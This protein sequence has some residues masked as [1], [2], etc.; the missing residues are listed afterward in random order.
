MDAKKMKAGMKKQSDG[1]RRSCC[2]LVFWVCCMALQHWCAAQ[3]PFEVEAFAKID[4]GQFDSVRY[5]SDS[6]FALYREEQNVAEWLNLKAELG[7]KLLQKKH[8]GEPLFYADEAMYY[9]ESALRDVWGPKPPPKAAWRSWAKIHLRIG[10][11]YSQ[12]RGNFEQALDYYE[13]GRRFLQDSLGDD[14]LYLANVV[15]TPLGK[16]HQRFRDYD[17]ASQCFQDAIRIC[18][19]EQNQ[20]GEAIALNGMGIM[21]LG[22]GDYPRAIR[23]FERGGALDNLSLHPKALLLINLGLARLKNKEPEKAWQLS[24]EAKWQLEHSAVPLPRN[25]SLELWAD[26]HDNLGNLYQYERKWD[27]AKKHFQMFAAYQIE[28]FGANRRETAQAWLEFCDL[29]SDMGAPDSTLHYAQLAL[30]SLFPEVA[31]DDVFSNPLPDSI[32]V[33]HTLYLIFE[34]KVEALKALVARNPSDTILLARCLETCDLLFL[35]DELLRREYDF[36]LSKLER[37]QDVH[38]HFETALAAGYRLWQLKSN[39]VWKIRSWQYADQARDRLLIEYVQQHFLTAIARAPEELKQQLIKLQDSITIWQE[40]LYKIKYRS[41]ADTVKGYMLE[42]LIFKHQS[43]LRRQLKKFAQQNNSDTNKIPTTNLSAVQHLLLPRQALIEY[44]TGDSAIYSFVIT[45]TGMQMFCLRM[46]PHF[47]D[48]IFGLRSYIADPDISNKYTSREAA[49]RFCE[50]A[51]RLY[52]WLL[53]EQLTALSPLIKSLSIIPDGPL[54]A[55]PF[56]LL[57]EDTGTKPDFKSFP[58]LLRKYSI[59]YTGSANLWLE[60]NKLADSIAANKGMELFVGFFP[61]YPNS[62]TLDHTLSDVRRTLINDARY[63]LPD[64]TKEDVNLIT[65]LLNGQAYI[66]TAASEQRFKQVAGRYRILHFA[67][68]AVLED[69]N[70]VYSKLLFTHNPSDIL[71]DN[72]LSVNELYNLSLRAELAVLMACNTGSGPI[73]RGEGII[74]LS[75]A[76]TAAQ[77]PA[78]V[79]TLWE[80]PDQYTL[81]VM[82]SFYKYLK[83]GLYIDEALQ[84]AQLEYLN[85]CEGRFCN[86]LY[87]AGAVGAGAMRALFG[88]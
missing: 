32:Y 57:G 63:S 13:I 69:K 29:F 6:A 36:E 12:K 42:A 81:Q 15:L 9:L 51:N 23:W 87:W 11:V 24:Q 82:V 40:Q 19:R 60:Q 7:G 33:E 54:G 1:R 17:R 86:P 46:P 67:M 25:D 18:V 43:S 39:D 8:N 83:M 56:G 65:N 75:R 88:E 14:D 72:E 68:H 37:Q 48:T 10:A 2:A 64:V 27:D 16:M 22:K 4:L 28:K 58:Y 73:Q 55:I 30:N 80:V 5:Y 62:D 50:P 53:K 35:S 20:N 45:K 77:V 74:S 78:T 34:Q 76:F 59:S 31:A 70:P 41:E 66:G 85:G 79:M 44:F 49:R 84:R 61:E 52:G 21:E 38:R 47:K 3:S 71:E 26:L